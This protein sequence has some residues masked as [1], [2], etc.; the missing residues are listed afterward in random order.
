MKSGVLAISAVAC[1]VWLTMATEPITVVSGHSDLK[2]VTVK[3]EVATATKC[4]QTHGEAPQSNLGDYLNYLAADFENAAERAIDGR[5]SNADEGTRTDDTG[6]AE[7]YTASESVSEP[8]DYVAYEDQQESGTDSGT[9]EVDEPAL[10]YIGDFVVTFYDLCPECTG[11]WYGMNTTASGRDP[12]PWYTVAAGPSLPFGTRLFVEDFGEF[13]VMDRGV[14]DGALDILVNNH[15]EIPSYGV[16]A[17][18]V[19]IIGD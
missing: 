4:T 1:A 6:T 9:A 12:V 2:P 8:V 11:P 14:S 7:Q 19:Y 3:A 16:T 18:S 5:R 17:K 15:S 10:T 13:E